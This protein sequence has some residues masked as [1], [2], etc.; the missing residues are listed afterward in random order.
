[1]DAG[2]TLEGQP[3]GIA[4]G[5]AGSGLSKHALI[6]IRRRALAAVFAC[7]F[8]G[9]LAFAA[10]AQAATYNVGL[11]TDATGT[12]ATPT[13]G[14]CSLRQLINFENGLTT[15]PNPADTI[16]LPAGTYSLTNGP[17]VIQQ[18][19]T[20][21]GAG[22]RTTQVDQQTTSSTSRV[23][24]IV[25]N[26]KVNPTPTVTISGVTM[27]F[28]KA[29]SSNGFFGGDVRNQANLTL[30]EDFIEDG[31]T[32]SGSGGGISN[33]GGTLTLTHSLVWN[34]TSTNPNGGGDSG[35]IQNYGDDSVG[36]GDALDRQLD[37][38]QQR[39]RAR[40]RDLQLVRRAERRVLVD[41]RQRTP[42]RSPT[43]RSRSTPAARVRRTG[44][45]LLVSE[46]TISVENSIVASNTVTN[47]LT[48]GQMPSNCGASSP[49]VITSLGNNLETATDCGF[50]AAGDLQSTNPGFL[51]SG[52][53]FNGG[54]TETFAL[55]GTSPA[56]DAV[57]ATAPGC[58][59]TD[60]RDIARPQGT[61]CDIGGY[62]LFQPVEGQQFTTGLGR[63]GGTSATID[64]G[65]K[66]A[67][68]A[69]HGRFARAGD[70]DAHLRGG[71]R[72][73]RDDQLEEQRRRQRADAVRAEGRRRAADRHADLDHR[74]RQCRLQR[75]GGDVHRRRSERHRLG[76]LRDD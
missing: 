70:R 11:T 39:I 72:L 61:G 44:G 15:T 54:N 53:A 34:N 1:M 22:A 36:A 50:K 76:L 49:G 46:G 73:P 20:I 27:A 57:A 51:T 12:C 64:W 7:W 63:I 37:D 69:G 26:P 47:P 62:E 24:D 25:G 23:F 65:D 38:R 60:Q 10:Q 40:R 30:S 75:R 9:V 17:L 52:L 33:D 4:G 58:S 45:G 14:K 8:V 41:R 21:S 31:Q 16:V 59:G 56:V 66:T 35:G 55:S 48:G 68:V 29:D 32:T 42:R 2:Q 43:R 13:S 74:H 6:V 19:L 67:H 71:G 28:G 5:Y 18:S 3:E